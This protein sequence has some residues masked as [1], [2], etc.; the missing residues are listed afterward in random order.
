MDQKTF[1]TWQKD[2]SISRLK[3]RSNSRRGAYLFLQHVKVVYDHSDKEIECE[4]WTTDDENDEV[5]VSVEVCLPLRLQV[6]TSSV[7]SIFHHLHPSLEGRHLKQGQVSDADVVE[8][9]FAVLP[10][11]VFA[12]A[13]FLSIHYLK[14][15]R[16]RLVIII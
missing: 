15:K 14:S 3:F 8:S 12:I 1:S 5:E 6:H 10:R 4:E 9:D 2:D 11:I 16:K 13:L 7:D